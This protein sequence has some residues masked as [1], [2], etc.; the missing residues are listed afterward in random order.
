MDYV[1]TNDGEKLS[2]RSNA[3]NFT[4]FFTRPST[5]TVS[6]SY[7]FNFRGKSLSMVMVESTIKQISFHYDELPGLYF[8]QFG[9]GTTVSNFN[10]F[11]CQLIANFLG[12]VT[13]S[14]LLES[15]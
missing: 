9:T 6:V 11:H 13:H 7:G 15:N 10:W 5:N 3:R 14:K 1:V 4:I 8:I 12:L 2:F